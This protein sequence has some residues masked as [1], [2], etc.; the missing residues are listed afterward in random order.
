MY[1]PE[2][3]RILII[4][5]FDIFD[6]F[7]RF[8]WSWTIQRCVRS[9]CSRSRPPWI[10]WSTPS[11][12]FSSPDSEDIDGYEFSWLII[13][14][15]QKR[16]IPWSLLLEL[17]PRFWGLGLHIGS[18]DFPKFEEI[19]STRLVGSDK[20]FRMFFISAW[21]RF[22]IHEKQRTP[23]ATGALWFTQPSSELYILQD[24][25]TEM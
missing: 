15:N 22:V 14:D 12:P 10:P 17:S 21:S 4:P 3:K 5:L 19:K 8:F 18:D 11:C 23:V 13:W 24:S 1:S 9:R 16:S 6:E 2:V 20:K 7:S 25:G